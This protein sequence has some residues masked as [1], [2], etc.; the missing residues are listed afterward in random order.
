MELTV[1]QLGKKF[2]AFYG[3]RMFI[4]V[5]TTARQWPFPE[6]DASSSQLPTLLR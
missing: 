3:T 4:I 5:F 2:P 6:P 1:S